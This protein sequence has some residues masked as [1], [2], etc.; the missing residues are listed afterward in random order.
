MKKTA[1]ALSIAAT[2]GCNNFQPS[3]FNTSDFDYA[4]LTTD[5][6]INEV[7]VF[8]TLAQDNTCP[9]QTG[10]EVVA[11]LVVAGIG[12]IAKEAIAFG[13]SELEK[14]A[15]YLEAD[16]ILNGR[17]LMPREWP[18]AGAASQ[19]P[20]CLLIVAGEYKNGGNGD[21]PLTK[22]RDSQKP[23]MDLDGDG[24]FREL[25]SSYTINIPGSTAIK[26]PFTD[27][28]KDP[29]FMAELIIT[30]KDLGGGKWL[31]HVTP[32]YLLY[33]S[34]LHKLAANGVDRKLAIDYTLGKAKGSIAL[35]GFKSGGVY[36]EGR[37]KTRYSMT[38]T[39]GNPAFADISITVTEGPDKMPTAKV[40]RQIASKDKDLEKYIDDK[41]SELAQ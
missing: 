23:L 20:V 4:K 21:V 40:L 31:Y 19:T 14:R 35:D 39:T 28:T 5:A 9:M 1:L 32:T 16:V 33:P 6:A 25:M 38:D 24:G 2:A 22:F 26:G 11:P 41:L 3:S 29:S 34:P 10:Q 17:S 12:Y 36:G 27:L 7:R 15:E 8:Q 37:M 13:K 18:V 30:T